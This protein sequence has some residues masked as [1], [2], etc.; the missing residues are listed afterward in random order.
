MG[1]PVPD[2]ALPTP[3]ETSKPDSPQEKAANTPW[4]RHSMGASR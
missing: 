4:G 3:M 2:K 1:L